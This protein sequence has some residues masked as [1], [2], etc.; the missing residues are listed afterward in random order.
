MDRGRRARR[1]GRRRGGGLAVRDQA[2]Q[3]CRRCS[4]SGCEPARRLGGCAEA[5]TCGVA[6]ANRKHFG[7]RGC[8]CA[9]VAGAGSGS[10]A[11]GA[12]RHLNRGN[13]ARP[14]QGRC[15]GNR[16]ATGGRDA[17]RHGGQHRRPAGGRRSQ[18]SVRRDTQP[19]RRGNRQPRRQ[20]R[21]AAS[22]RSARAAQRCRRH[23]QREH[24]QPEHASCG[25]ARVRRHCVGS[26]AAVWHATVA[27]R[28]EL[29]PGAHHD[30]GARAGRARRTTRCGA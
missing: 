11:G 22:G 25:L 3:R 4:G 18:Q 20:R 6:A 12:C 17:Q 16:A 2:R 1:R 9:A 23:R 30:S 29:S 19:R 26:G 28:V 21:A 27:G 13:H 15:T 14:G 7:R 5:D 8:C 24:G 10:I